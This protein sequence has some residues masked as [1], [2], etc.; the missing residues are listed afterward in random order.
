MNKGFLAEK[1]EVFFKI[2]IEYSSNDSISFSDYDLETFKLFLDCLFGFKEYTTEI[3]LVIF[4]IAHKYQV[5]EGLEKCIEK[6]TP[7]ELNENLCITLNL[8]LFYDCDILANRI[9]SFLTDDDEDD[10]DEVEEEGDVDDDSDN[11]ENNGGEDDS[12]DGED[13]CKI[14]EILYNEKYLNLLEPMAIL[15]LLDVVKVNENVINVLCNWGEN[16]LKK[17]NISKD[18]KSFFFENKILDRITLEQFSTMESIFV[19]HKT[20]RTKAF[21]SHKK[22]LDFMRKE[23]LPDLDGEWVEV[24][25]EDTLTE[26]FVFDPPIPMVRDFIHHLDVCRNEII[27]EKSNSSKDNE[28]AYY[29]EINH[30]MSDQKC[31]TLKYDDEMD[32]RFDCFDEHLL[33]EPKAKKYCRIPIDPYKNF[34]SDK[35][36]IT[37]VKIMYTFSIDCR[38][39]KTPSNDLISKTPDDGVN[40]FFTYFIESYFKM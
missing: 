1:S 5:S 21:F 36:G 14:D 38:I 9:V 23:F 8:S 6:L 35:F 12:V 20:P 2:L 28:V 24:K 7:V 4:P 30:K 19:F 34:S 27:V 39:L 26:T 32:D 15:K 37:E 33:E 25:K 3:A 17:N 11:D 31:E 22:I 10:E 16:Y 40:K 18:L 13:K 29:M